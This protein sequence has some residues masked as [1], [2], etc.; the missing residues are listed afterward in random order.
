MPAN[1]SPEYLAADKRFRAARTLSEKILA[2]EEMLSVIPKH[3]GT[4]KMQADIKRRLSKL[5]TE[6]EKRAGR[7]G[8]SYSISREGA[9]QVLVAGL[10]NVG[11]SSLVSRLTNAP[12]TVADYP[13]TTQMPV[14]GMM[15]Y[16]NVQIQ[17]V[18]MPPLMYE[19]ADPWYANMS[20][21]ADLIVAVVDLTDDPATQLEL[22]VEELARFRIRPTGRPG[23]EGDTYEMEKPM[24]VLGCKADHPNAGEGA[25][26][27]QHAAR[28]L[29]VLI[30]STTT[31]EGLEYVR[32]EVYRLLDLIR[33]YTRA[34]GKGPDMKHPFVLKRG[35]TMAELAGEIHQDFL[36]K[37]RYGRVWGQGK[38]DGQKV[39]LDYHLSDGD[40]IELRI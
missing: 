34:P 40:V 26:E 16:E 3:K 11:K 37:F 25:A 33:V 5:R 32:A 38:F 1:L 18:D 20:R 29:P 4:E 24:L 10:P 36:E 2:L 7:R 9:G 19:P 13:Y 17:L 31:G 12:S 22:I 15:F 23:K 27:L 35:S 39:N 14:P 21:V 28:G 30:I 6:G 8:F